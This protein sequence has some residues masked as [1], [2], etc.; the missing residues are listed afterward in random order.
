[1]RVK[2]TGNK[3]AIA[4]PPLSLYAVSVRKTYRRP[5]YRLGR[6]SRLCEQAAGDFLHYLNG[7]PTCL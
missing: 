2:G 3:T 6:P 1:M 4:H 5:S 7:S